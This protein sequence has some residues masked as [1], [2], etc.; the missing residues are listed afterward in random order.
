M[1][2]TIKKIRRSETDQE[3]IFAKDTSD[4]EWLAKIYKE[5]LNPK[6]EKTNN[7]LKK[8]TKDFNR[9]FAKGDVQ[10]TSLRKD[11]PHHMSAG[12]CKFQQGGATAR[13]LGGPA[14]GTLTTPNAGEVAGSRDSHSLLVRIQNGSHLRR[15]WQFRTALSILLPRDPAMTLLDIYPKELKT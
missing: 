3:K 11:V 8:W 5:L 7:H 10:M 4:K 12:K 13:L 14:S 15:Q 2:D 1:K 9:R 6:G